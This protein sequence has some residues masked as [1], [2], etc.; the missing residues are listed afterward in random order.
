MST[1]DERGSAIARIAL[2]IPDKP[3][4]GDLLR[5][6]HQAYEAGERKGFGDGFTAGQRSALGVINIAHRVMERST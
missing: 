5:A 2:E 3:T 4:S 6:L 1:P